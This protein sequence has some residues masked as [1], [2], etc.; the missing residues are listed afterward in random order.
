MQFDETKELIKIF[1]SK[2]K[3]FDLT[4]ETMFNAALFVAA[5]YAE[6]LKKPPHDVADELLTIIAE[7]MILAGRARRGVDV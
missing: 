5:I 1:V 6:E 3:E 7:I 2:Q 4:G